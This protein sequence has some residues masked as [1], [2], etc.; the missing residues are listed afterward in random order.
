MDTARDYGEI[1]KLQHQVSVVRR[2]YLDPVLETI[3]RCKQRRDL[4]GFRSRRNSGR[5]WRDEAAVDTTACQLIN[6]EKYSEL[7]Y[8]KLRRL[9][10]IHAIIEDEIERNRANLRTRN[11]WWTNRI[12]AALPDQCISKKVKHIRTELNDPEFTSFA[13]E[14]TNLVSRPTLLPP[15]NL[16]HILQQKK[17]ELK[18]LQ[19]QINLE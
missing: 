9:R 15:A 10:N 16:Q 4:L 19:G 5:G 11:Q 6:T 13:E 8:D 3:H 7:L 12:D 2:K 1:K 14:F 18:N 17:E